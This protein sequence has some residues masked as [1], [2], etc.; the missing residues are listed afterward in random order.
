M[1]L[2]TSGCETSPLWRVE[3]AIQNA[4]Y[5]R[6]DLPEATLKGFKMDWFEC[7]SGAWYCRLRNPHLTLNNASGVLQPA[8]VLCLSQIAIATATALKT[9]PN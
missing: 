7:R 8:T 3:L 9:P 1:K 6:M 2:N 4:N 5:S